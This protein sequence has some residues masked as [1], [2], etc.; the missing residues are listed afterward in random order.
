MSL[1]LCPNNWVQYREFI[2]LIG[3]INNMKDLICSS[4]KD[5]IEQLKEYW[6]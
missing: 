1:I 6:S 3:E 2:I 4:A 5:I